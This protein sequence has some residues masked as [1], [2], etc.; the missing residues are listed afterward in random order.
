MLETKLQAMKQ[1]DTVFLQVEKQR[2]RLVF[3]SF[4]DLK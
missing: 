1:F 2:E 3:K 4:V